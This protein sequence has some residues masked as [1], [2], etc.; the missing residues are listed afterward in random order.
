MKIGPP[1]PKQDSPKVAKTTSTR[2]PGEESKEK[3]AQSNPPPVQAT[4]TAPPVV[5]TITENNEEDPNAADQIGDAAHS[6]RP[7]GRPTTVKPSM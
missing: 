6:A 7:P 4:E 1:Q 2:N 5:E 3:D